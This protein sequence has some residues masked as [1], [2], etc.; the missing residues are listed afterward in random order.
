MKNIEVR[1]L[2]AFVAVAEELNYR[3]AAQRLHV[4]QPALSRTIQQL[5][6]EVGARLLDRSTTA[7]Q[8]TEVGVFL[9]DRRS[10]SVV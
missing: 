6:G 7:V 10:K 1:H 5:E 2:R 4:A 9:L 8:L 3:K